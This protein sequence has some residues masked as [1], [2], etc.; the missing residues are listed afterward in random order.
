MKNMIITFWKILFAAAIIALYAEIAE[1]HSVGRYVIEVQDER[2]QNRWTLTEWLRI[3]ERMRMMDLWLALFSD[4]KK[5]NKFRPEL[6]LSYGLLNGVIARD[7]A[8]GLAAYTQN[9]TVQKGHLWL[10]N[11]VSSTVGVR[12]LNID[13][14]I[15]GLNR[16]TDSMRSAEISGV[17]SNAGLP[18]QSHWTGMLRIFGKNIQDSSL[19]L[20]YGQYNYPYHLGWTADP[21]QQSLHGV[22]AG[23]EV[24]LYLFKWLGVESNYYQYG[25]EVSVKSKSI[26][27]RYVDYMGYIEISLLRV[28]IGVYAEEWLTTTP[29]ESID[30]KGTGAFTGLKIQI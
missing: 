25:D 9:S 22:V 27:G 8:S 1:G 6:S 24:S 28:M 17:G 23:G 21:M 5:D 19:I 13:L 14:G 3:K 15:E 26:S 20:K 30:V 18:T 10:T 7:S 11:L 2:Y 4:P 29:T 16:A 12:T